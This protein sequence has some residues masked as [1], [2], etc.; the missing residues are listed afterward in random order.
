VIGRWRDRIPISTLRVDSGMVVN[1]LLM[2]FN[3]TSPRSGG[4]PA[5][6][7]RPHSAPP[8]RRLAVGT[9]T[10][11]GL[12][13]NWSVQHTWKPNARE[14]RA[15]DRLMA[16]GGHARTFAGREMIGLRAWRIPDVAYPMA[17]TVSADGF[18]AP[19]H[20]T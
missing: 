4:A 9:G 2:Q 8:M 15:S 18:R 10:A 12:L 3:P 19:A 7:R 11:P 20:P 6:R 14:Q 5:P 17:R 1:A 13:R 16:Q